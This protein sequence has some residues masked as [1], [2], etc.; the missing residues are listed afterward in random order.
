MSKLPEG[1]KALP[2]EWFVDRANNWG[3]ISPM[4]DEERNRA[5]EK[6]KANM[7]ADEI[8]AVSLIAQMKRLNLTV[9]EALE[10]MQIFAND[11]QFQKDLDATYSNMILDDWDYWHEGDIE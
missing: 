3:Q 7:N 10:A 11:K 6:E 4:T 9:T 2:D 1:R 5:K 8:D